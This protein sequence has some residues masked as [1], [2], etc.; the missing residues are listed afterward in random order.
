[1]QFVYLVKWII[2]FDN[3]DRYPQNTWQY[4]YISPARLSK[5]LYSVNIHKLLPDLHVSVFLYL[6]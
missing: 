1:M 6:L 5:L 4:M 2:M 3:Y